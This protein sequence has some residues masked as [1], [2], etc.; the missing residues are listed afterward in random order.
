[1]N[2][3]N[4]TILALRLGPI[5]L[6]LTLSNGSSGVEPVITVSRSKKR[7]TKIGAPENPPPQLALPIVANDNEG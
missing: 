1:M 2:A 3:L 5:K 7:T 4:L 6:A